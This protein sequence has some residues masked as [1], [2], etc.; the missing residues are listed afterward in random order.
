MANI[1]TIFAVLLMLLI[2]TSCHYTKD[3]EFRKLNNLSV[4]KFGFTESQVKANLELYNPNDFTLDLGQSDLDIYLDS[5]L[6]G[7]SSQTLEVS[8]PKKDVFT[9]PITL[10]VNMKNFLRNGLG[11]LLNSNVAVR[12]LGNVK[13]GKAGIYKNFKVDFTTKQQISLF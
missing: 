12:A 11:S 6:I 8:I 13:V 3:I 5:A 4:V 10:N 9:V 7:H 2:M 1:K